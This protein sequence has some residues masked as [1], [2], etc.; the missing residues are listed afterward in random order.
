MSVFG[1]IE[2]FFFISLALVFVLVI[3]LVYHFKNRIT[4]AEKKSESMYG[5]LTAVVKEIKTLRGMFGLGGTVSNATE[6]EV[7]VERVE[8]KGQ[9]KT[10]PEVNVRLENENT[11]NTFAGYIEKISNEKP[12]EVITMEITPI[13]ERITIPI[14]I[15]GEFREKDKI[16]VSDDDESTISDD[17]DE[18][19]SDTES[20]SDADTESE[21]DLEIEEPTYLD[22]K[23]LDINDVTSDYAGQIE[24]TI[25]AE[26]VINVGLSSETSSQSDMHN[27][28]PV[29]I[30]LHF[31][32]SVENS[33]DTRESEIDGA[34][35]NASSY[36]IDDKSSQSTTIHPPT[37][38][39]NLETNIQPDVFPEDNLQFNSPPSDSSIL[40]QSETETVE[41]VEEL[42]TLNLT[43]VSFSDDL[44]QSVQNNEPVKPSAE[45]LRKM[46]INQLKNIASQIGITTDVSKMK[47]PELIAL[48]L[49]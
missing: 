19:G 14:S 30:H 17:T 29:P 16:V 32:P 47:K 10:T 18:S 43:D 44:F 36:E 1:F 41:N 33:G 6:P 48:I 31:L 49:R 9:T 40:H 42:Q 23:T 4:V 22:I 13:Q 2:N 7:P 38:V 12:R 24:L 25:S 15:A 26:E 5:L 21:S 20:D 27:L 37:P 46:N 45:Q 8:F 39:S 34:L 11:P 28:E 35:L 3:F